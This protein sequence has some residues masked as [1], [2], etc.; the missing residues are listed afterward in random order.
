M[1]TVDLHPEEL[2]DA[3]RAGPLSAADRAR[4]EDHCAQ[5]PACRFELRWLDTNASPAQPSAEDRAYG[6]AAFDHVLR[7]RERVKDAQ[8]IRP[9]HRPLHGGLGGLLLGAAV[10]LAFFGRELWSGSPHPTPPEARASS[11]QHTHD[12]VPPPDLDARSIEATIPRSQPQPSAT[13]SPTANA[14]LA[15]ARKA[16]TQNHSSRAQHLYQQVIQ[17]YPS[18]A[19]AGA[20]RV[21]L[22]RLIFD[23][24]GDSRAALTLFDEYLQQHPTGTLAEEALYYR[25]SSLDRLGRKRQAQRDLRELLASFPS[26]VYAAPA[27]AQLSHEQGE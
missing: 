9:R 25:A 19:A 14:L 1:S 4:L 23:E 17:R 12:V 18:T 10:S 8:D 2:F 13:S 6:E 27:R 16:R 11:Q 3:L 15:A 26:S 24:R 20:A 5:C 21:A 7:A 22:G